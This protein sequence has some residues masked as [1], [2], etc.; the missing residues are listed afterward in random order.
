MLPSF[1]T[2]SVTRLRASTTT[3][4]GNTIPDWTS[5]SSTAITGCSV[6]PGTTVEDLSHRDG[7]LI[8]WIVYAPSG[9]DVLASDRIQY[10]GNTY[11]VVGEPDRF[12]TGILDH[13]AFR[14]KRWE[15]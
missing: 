13:V 11:E 5:P 4:H 8:E 6:Q 14:L 2:Q 10:G 15:G 12:Q 7:V 3:D 1:A 9:T